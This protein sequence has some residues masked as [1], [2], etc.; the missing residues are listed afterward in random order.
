M[1]F[2][3]KSHAI[4][5]QDLEQENKEKDKEITKLNL[6]TTKS[7]SKKEMQTIIDETIS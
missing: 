2:S 4:E 6:A 3:T 7:K 1:G 5:V